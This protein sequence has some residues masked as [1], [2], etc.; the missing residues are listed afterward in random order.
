MLG[1]ADATAYDLRFRLFGVAVRVNPWFW[2][3]MLMIAGRREELRDTLIFVG[4]AFVSILV[5]EFGHGLSGRFLGHEPNEIVLY[6]FGG[7]CSF[8]SW[9][10]KAWRQ[11]VILF[12]GPA[13]GFLLLGLVILG[14][15]LAARNDSAAEALRSPVAMVIFFDLA[16]INLVWG[17]LNLFPIW[18]LDGGR[19]TEVLLTS[20]TPDNGKRWTHVISLLTAGTL[21]LWRF[22][23]GDLSGIWFALFAIMNY[24]VLQAMH[25]GY[26][27]Y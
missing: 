2:L 27:S 12:C 15:E 8:L 14:V 1:S 3:V 6:G 18:P 25:Q 7:Y 26:H 13:A 11:I 19:I 4:C 22:T 17:I 9:P 21:S 16:W 23:S 20:W 24:Q 10:W 5:H